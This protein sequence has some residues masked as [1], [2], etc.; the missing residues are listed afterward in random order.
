MII[1][2]ES[3][4]ESIV[5]YSM[6]DADEY[7]NGAVAL[8]A[9]WVEQTVVLCG[10]ERARA[11]VVDAVRDN[12]SIDSAAAHVLTSD[13]FLMLEHRATVCGEGICYQVSRDLVRPTVDWGDNVPSAFCVYLDSQR[14]RL[15]WYRKAGFAKNGFGIQGELFELFVVEAL[16]HMGW[17]AERTGWGGGRLSRAKEI[18]RQVAAWI[19]GTARESELSKWIPRS[20]K[21]AKLDLV[22]QADFYDGRGLRPTFL[23]QCASGANWKDKTGSPSVRTWSRVIAT[24]TQLSRGFAMPHLVDEYEFDRAGVDSGAL[25]LDSTRLLSA[26]A[27]DGG[28]WLSEQLRKRIARWLRP[29][30]HALAGTFG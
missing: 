7:A 15:R 9:G 2:P 29:R 10:E 21:D 4:L 3:D 24:G 14:R 23:V 25:F 27:C 16:A 26:G 18:V 11:D 12:L 30:I 22:C 17:R 8:V 13:A 20:A 5:A 1:A 6:Q 28:D 19:D